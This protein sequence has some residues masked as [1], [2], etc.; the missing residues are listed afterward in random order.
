MM[1][2]P[3]PYRRCVT[4]TFKEMPPAAVQLMEILLSIDPTSRGTAEFALKSEVCILFYFLIF[5]SFSPYL[6]HPCIHLPLSYGSQVKNK[7]QF[8]FALNMAKYA[9][10]L[11]LLILIFNK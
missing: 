5:F 3:Q 11:L 6:N 9:F 8:D 7:D 2:P 1:K 10:A 4:E